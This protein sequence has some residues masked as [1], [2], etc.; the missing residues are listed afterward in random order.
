MKLYS[1]KTRA[2]SVK[3]ACS[4]NL[5]AFSDEEFSKQIQELALKF[6]LS[7]DDDDETAENSNQTV[8]EEEEMSMNM[9][10]N[11]LSSMTERIES[12][13]WEESI[14]RKANSIE[15]PFS[16]RILKRKKQWHE[17][18]KAAGESTY[19]S[20]KKAFSSMVF[21]IRELQSYTLHMRE[22]LFFEDLHEVLARVQNDMNDSFVWLFQQVFSQTPTLMVY[23]MI[24]LAN[25]SVFSLSNSAAIQSPPQQPQIMQLISLSNSD[26]QKFD[27]SAIKTSP[28]LSSTITSIDGNNGGGGNGK[29]PV[30][31]S[32]TEG[33]GSVSSSSSYHRSPATGRSGE[34]ESVSGID[35]LRR[36]NN[37]VDE[38]RDMETSSIDHETMHGFVSPVSVKIEEDDY[39]DGLRTEQLY[40]TLLVQDPT[41]SLLLANYA[42]F[43]FLVL[44]DHSRAE[45]YFKRA[46]KTEPKDAEAVSKYAR[47]LW[48]A[49]NDLWAAEETF[50]EA[51][52]IEPTN[53]YY[54]SNYANFLWE[55]GAEDTCYLED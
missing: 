35:E 21:I 38:A 30:I 53:S 7:N 45:H 15:I 9:D 17:G 41:N 3:R 6:R 34:E 32:G 11:F 40:Q 8:V 49:Q 25:Y 20:V 43:L 12:P 36:W 1:S 42:Q 44:Q 51:I 5:D 33:D 39:K 47:F 48:L 13:D 22:I 19:S 4:A 27:S 14:E 28:I 46:I 24:L 18:I 26:Y 16:I 50:L 29:S 2:R 55:T 52:A 54:A 23:V 10:L 31:S 37:I